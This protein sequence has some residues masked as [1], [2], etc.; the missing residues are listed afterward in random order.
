M[1]AGPPTKYSDNILKQVEQYYVEVDAI[2]NWMPTMEEI[3]L[4]LGINGDTLVEWCK[5]HNEL[6]AAIKR[7]KDLQKHRLQAMGLF[8]KVN[9]TMAIFL[10]KANHGLVDVSRQ[11][12]TGKDGEPIETTTSLTYMPKQLPDDY[13]ANKQVEA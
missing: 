10:L 4:K 12:H 7:I 2:T 9:P 1:P 8:N 11:E 6:S 13:Y 5:E 3:A